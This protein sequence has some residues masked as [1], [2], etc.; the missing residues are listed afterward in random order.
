MPKMAISEQEVKEA[1]VANFCSRYINYYN[2]HKDMMHK[3][4]IKERAI[5][6]GSLEE[7]IQKGLMTAKAAHDMEITLLNSLNPDRYINQYLI[8]T[9][10]EW[11]G[12]RKHF[13]PKYLKDI[14]ALR[15]KGLNVTVFET[16]VYTL[17]ESLQR[18]ENVIASLEREGKADDTALR[19]ALIAEY[20]AKDMFL[21]DYRDNKSAQA[22]MKRIFQM[23]RR[24]SPTAIVIDVNDEL[25]QL[26]ESTFVSEDV[27]WIF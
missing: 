11:I 10:S 22:A 16:A 20:R 8:T 24:K 13:E 15:A 7:M 9:G 25:L 19:H 14:E 4:G 6:K 5:L 12:G 26:F 18:K 27:K 1:I 2:A 23:E 17:L 21:Q 3:I